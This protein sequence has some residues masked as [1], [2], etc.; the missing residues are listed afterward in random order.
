MKSLLSLIIRMRMWN[1]GLSQRLAWNGLLTG[2]RQTSKTFFNKR[3]CAAQPHQGRHTI[4]QGT[5][6]PYPTGREETRWSNLDPMEKRAFSDLGCD[7]HRHIRAIVLG[8]DI[9]CGRWSGG[10][11]RD[12]KAIQIR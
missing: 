7:N 9:S 2:L 5:G 4:D 3:D 1:N 6:W 8:R 12:Q 11:S 10:N